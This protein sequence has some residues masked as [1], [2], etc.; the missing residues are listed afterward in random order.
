MRNGA[1]FSKPRVIFEGNPGDAQAYLGAAYALLFKVRQFCQQ[2]GATVFGM[3]RAMPDGAVIS[4]SVV[5][6]QESVS[7]SPPAG[8]SV[9]VEMIEE[10]AEV[11]E[12]VEDR[13]E[14]EYVYVASRDGS[15]VKV[16]RYM[17]GMKGA[18]QEML[19]VEETSERTFTMFAVGA[20]K[21]FYLETEWPGSAP[22]PYVVTT[23]VK[24]WDGQTIVAYQREVGEG[25]SPGPMAT[26]F[27]VSEG[28]VFV[29]VKV[30]RSPPEVSTAT[31][32]VFDHMGEALGS[33]DLPT[34][35]SYDDY[36]WMD[37][38][39]G[40]IY[41]QTRQLGG[42][43]AAGIEAYTVE[44]AP[45]YTTPAGY[46]SLPAGGAYADRFVSWGEYDRFRVFRKDGT[47]EGQYTLLPGGE[48]PQAKTSALSRDFL[49]LAYALPDARYVQV[50]RRAGGVLQAL[51]PIAVP[52][53]FALEIKTDR[54]CLPWEHKEQR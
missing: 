28:K 36:E 51:D 21:L 17:A 37:Y 52:E 50:Y 8:Q 1:P 13:R 32:D 4:A 23:T 16:L 33:F 9:R 39:A 53:G 11:V 14:Y 25:A 34:P 54:R 35:N 10:P 22:M 15:T 29:R 47:L 49:H 5:G 45:L 19:A 40:R 18:P 20:G 24:R 6:D 12:A 42:T 2:S 26:G 44:G 7:C 30:V 46:Y 31:I 27:T 41:L 48:I 43:D 38:A 3:S